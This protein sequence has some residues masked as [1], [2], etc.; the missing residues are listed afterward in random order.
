[1]FVLLRLQFNFHFILKKT[2]TK[3]STSSHVNLAS[4]GKF[5]LIYFYQLSFRKFNFIKIYNNVDV[6]FFLF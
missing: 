1:M 2:L 5:Y 4:S 3:F 6:A